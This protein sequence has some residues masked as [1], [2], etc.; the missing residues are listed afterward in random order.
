MTSTMSM[1]PTSAQRLANS[2]DELI[3]VAW[4]AFEAY[5]IISAVLG[6]C[7]GVGSRGKPA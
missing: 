5:L 1:S 7:E 4:S 3:N 2:F 6:W